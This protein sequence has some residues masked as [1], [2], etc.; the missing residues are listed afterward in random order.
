[1][2]V[3]ASDM[4]SS[5]RRCHQGSA[6]SG[7]MKRSMAIWPDTVNRTRSDSWSLLPANVI[8]AATPLGWERHETRDRAGV[9][10]LVKDRLPQLAD[11][12]D[13]HLRL[14][15]CR[16]PPR[17]HRSR[18]C[19]AAPAAAAPAGPGNAGRWPAPARARGAGSRSSST[20]AR[21]PAPGWRPAAL[22]RRA[23][24][25]ARTP[26]PARPASSAAVMVLVIE[27]ISNRASSGSPPVPANAGPLPLSTAATA[28]TIPSPA[29]APS[30]ASKTAWA[31]SEPS[32]SMDRSHVK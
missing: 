5:S 16:H 28:T 21:N 18:S 10:D 20:G 3:H 25:S 31:R 9:A 4:R 8:R 1:M 27:P 30:Y 22:P 19:R 14:A 12:L 17:R 2:I 13:R 23:R 26:S 15:G 7:E 24:S 29:N 6:S 11:V 32:S